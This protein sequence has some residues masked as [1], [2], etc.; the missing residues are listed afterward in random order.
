MVIFLVKRIIMFS[1]TSALLVKGII[2]SIIIHFTARPILAF[3][4]QLLIAQLLGIRSLLKD[5]QDLRHHRFLE[6][7]QEQ[8][9][10]NGNT[11][12]TKMMGADSIFT[13]DPDNI[14][15]LLAVKFDHYS[16]GRRRGDAFIPYMGH[17]IISAD[18]EAWARS[19]QLLRSSFTLRQADLAIFEKHVGHMLQ[20]IPSNCIAIDLQPVFF[21]LAMD[22]ASEFFLGE[23]TDCLAPEK[24]KSSSVEFSERFSQFQCAIRDRLCLGK[25]PILAPTVAFHRN[26]RYIREFVDN[27]IE[28]ASVAQRQRESER[29]DST[30]KHNFLID[31][32]TRS[33][34]NAIELREDVLH[35]FLGARDT[36]GSLLSNLWFVLAR[37]PDIWEKLYR[38][39]LALGR[40]RPLLEQLKG[41]KY[42]HCCIKE[43]TSVHDINR[44]LSDPA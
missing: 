42:M 25:F 30:G 19:R 8:F 15:T 16:V 35:L 18:G 32:L 24:L 43:C 3:F 26:R 14:R 33:P 10:H 7:T 36:T 37:R 6:A 40:G 4:R 20:A 13:I 22:I 9:N 39:V 5:Y 11:Y 38:E 41:M 28:K 44:A 12:R 27:F 17:S 1:I 29:L 31:K 23:S 21:H 34:K 2:L